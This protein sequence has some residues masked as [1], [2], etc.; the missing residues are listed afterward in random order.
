MVKENI[1]IYLKNLYRKKGMIQMDD[2][3]KT[4]TVFCTFEKVVEID[5][6]MTEEEIQ[7]L[8]SD[9]LASDEMLENIID[10]GFSYQ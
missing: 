6:N 1:R 8:A 2:K 3:I 4:I 5:D 7:E 10:S 9:I